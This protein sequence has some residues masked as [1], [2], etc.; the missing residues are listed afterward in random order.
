MEDKKKKKYHE[1]IIAKYYLCSVLPPPCCRYKFRD[2][3]VK[4]DSSSAT[5]AYWGAWNY[6]NNPETHAVD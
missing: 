1:T 6:R 2:V 3:N 4:N 5:A